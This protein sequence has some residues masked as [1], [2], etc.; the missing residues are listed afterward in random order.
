MFDTSVDPTDLATAI[1]DNVEASATKPVNVGLTTSKLP[2]GVTVTPSPSTV[3]DVAPGGTADF[4]VTITGIG[5][6]SSAAF[7]IKFVDTGSGAQLGSC[8]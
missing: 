3:S 2:A 1:E 8:R 5:A 7:T 4:N 6:A